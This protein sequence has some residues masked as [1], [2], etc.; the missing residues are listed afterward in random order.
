MNDIFSIFQIQSL[1][2]LFSLYSAFRNSQHF[3][4]LAQENQMENALKD[5]NS[6]IEF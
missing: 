4:Q 1:H 5:S 3:N 2:V 6:K